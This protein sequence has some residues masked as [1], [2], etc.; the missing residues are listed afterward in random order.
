MDKLNIA[1]ADDNA[2]VLQL[3]DKI[4][5]SDEELNVVGKAGNGEDLYDIIKKQEPDVVLL[6]LVMPKVD[7]LTVM[8]RV[9]KDQEI[10]KH[11][12]FIV[13]TAVGQEKITEDAFDLGAD[14]YIMKPFDNDMVISRIK[15]VKNR[16]VARPSEVRKV[17][18]YEKREE[19]KERNL[20]AD[21]TAIIYEI[22][23][24]AHIKGYQYIREGIMMAVNDMNMLNY[25]TKLLYPSIAKKYKTTSS[26]VERA[27]RH[28]IEVAWGRG[29]IEVIED[30]F[31]YTVSAGKGKPTNSEFIALIADKL[32]IEYKMHAS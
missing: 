22:G 4:V 5:S 13:I 21:V 19:L 1:I 23:V 11:P 29:K 32:R 10:R 16:N 20:E 18:P 3:L 30:M 28:A 7:G 24:P 6:D 12:A 15:D 17:Q 14:Y 27:I 9:N 2:K 26:S 8:E 25:I 31:G